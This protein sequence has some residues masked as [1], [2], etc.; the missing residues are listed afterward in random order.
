MLKIESTSIA[1]NRLR[2]RFSDIQLEETANRNFTGPHYR[3]I[4]IQLLVLFLLF[5]A[6]MDSSV[7]SPYKS[8]LITLTPPPPEVER[9][10]LSVSTQSLISFGKTFLRVSAL[11]WKLAQSSV[12][13]G[14]LKH[15]YLFPL[16]NSGLYLFIG[17]EL[18]LHGGHLF[19]LVVPSDF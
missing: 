9:H 6:I 7:T 17:Q 16:P 14:H 15:N 1:L 10:Q 2:I 12:L 8:L 3:V 4:D 5:D 18:Y 11:I 13:R 19:A